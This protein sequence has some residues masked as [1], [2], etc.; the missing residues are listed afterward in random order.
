MK[1]STQYVF[2]RYQT[3]FT[4]ASSLLQILNQMPHTAFADKAETENNLLCAVQS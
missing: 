4:I 3:V 1:S 2:V